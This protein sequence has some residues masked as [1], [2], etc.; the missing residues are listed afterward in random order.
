MFN[1]CTFCSVLSHSDSYFMYRFSTRLYWIRSILNFTRKIGTKNCW[2]S[3]RIKKK[4]IVYFYFKIFIILIL[5]YEKWICHIDL[6][7]IIYNEN[8]EIFTSLEIQIHCSRTGIV[9][10]R[11]LFW[12]SEYPKISR[13]KIYTV[14]SV[15]L[16]HHS[17]F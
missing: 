11:Q 3:C 13:L 9:A 14:N 6:L 15:E 17:D 12:A 5:D 4:F 16:E 1:I 8:F 7:I 10:C 2:K